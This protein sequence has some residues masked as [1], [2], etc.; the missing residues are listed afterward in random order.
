VKKLSLVCLNWR[1]PPAAPL[2][3][4]GRL[5]DMVLCDLWR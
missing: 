5:P 4:A 2:L 1:G 3:S